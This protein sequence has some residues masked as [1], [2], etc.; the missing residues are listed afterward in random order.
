MDRLSTSLLALFTGLAAD[1]TNNRPDYA[2]A[3][4]RSALALVGKPVSDIDFVDV[5]AGTGIWTRMIAE[6]G[7]KSARAVEPNDDMRGEGQAFPT[8]GNIQW[9]NGSGENTTLPDNSA[10]ML[11]MASSFHWVIN[12][13][14][15][16]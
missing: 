16:G 12:A 1:Y 2:P 7:V 5:G 9:F 10:D 15:M 13:S 8:N 14:E 11:T 4:V 6:E 3:I